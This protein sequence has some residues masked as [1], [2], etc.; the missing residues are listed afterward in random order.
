MSTNGV[1]YTRQELINIQKMNSFLNPPTTGSYVVDQAMRAE[2][3][4]QWLTFVNKQQ[5]RHQ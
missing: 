1:N 2:R 5:S 3:K 4:K